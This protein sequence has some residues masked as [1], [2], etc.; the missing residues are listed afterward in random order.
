[1]QGVG[2]KA[3]LADGTVPA[4][5]TCDS[6]VWI[7]AN[8]VGNSAGA[9]LM[10]GH[11]VGI[12]NLD[13]A[14]YDTV[15]FAGD[16]PVSLSYKICEVDGWN[17]LHAYANF[18]YRR[19]DMRPTTRSK[20]LWSNDSRGAFVGSFSA[21]ANVVYDG[22]TMIRMPQRREFVSLSGA[23]NTRC[24]YGN[25][26]DSGVQGSWSAFH[27]QVSITSDDGSHADLNN[28]ANWVDAQPLTPFFASGGTYDYWG[29]CLWL[30]SNLAGGGLYRLTGLNSNVWRSERIAGAAALTTAGNGTFHRCQVAVK[31]TARVLMRVTST[32]SPPEVCR[33]A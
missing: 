9:L 31:G 29:N 28:P 4:S 10:F 11:T 1:M 23:V 8:V 7:P 12:V 26:F 32:T 17:V 27:D 19:W 2:G 25:G 24:R 3:P 22:K 6:L 33:I 15:H 5:H 13:T 18:Y 14:S 16:S 20:T 21:G 30:Q